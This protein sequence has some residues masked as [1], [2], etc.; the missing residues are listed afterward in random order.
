MPKVQFICL[1][2]S[3]K[4]GG[5]CVAGVR[6][7]GRGWI[8]PVSGHPGGT[9]FSEYRYVNGAEAALL[10][11]VEAD[12]IAAQPEAHQPENWLL[13]PGTWQLIERLPPG[14]AMQYLTPF[15]VPGPVL[16]ENESD[17]VAYTTLVQQPASASLALVEPH[18]IPWHITTNT[19]GQRQTRCDF[20][21]AGAR[22]DLAITDP[23][24]VPR[25]AELIYGYHLREVAGIAAEDRV[26]LTVSLGEPFEA[27]GHCYKLVAAVL[28]LPMT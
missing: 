20:N 4:I 24:F 19:Q 21:L 9:L 28:L 12:V 26:L 8:R 23:A 25:L 15:V 27:T 18:R 6:V 17:S 2:N 5:R 10:D 3:R 1:A 13:A 14:A 16:L 22:Y 7:D 11:I